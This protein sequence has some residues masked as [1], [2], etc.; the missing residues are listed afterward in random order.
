MTKELPISTRYWGTWPENESGTVE[1]SRTK[2]EN[3]KHGVKLSGQDSTA[4]TLVFLMSNF[5]STW[6]ILKLRKELPVP[7]IA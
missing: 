2:T 4:T 5:Q 3:W 6:E 7:Y 1:C